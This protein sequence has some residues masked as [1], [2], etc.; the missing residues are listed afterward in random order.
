MV[1]NNIVDVTEETFQRDV[2]DFSHTV[3]VVVDFWADWCQPCKTIG[4]MLEQLAEDYGGAFRLARVNVDQNQ[5]LATA[6]QVQSIPTLLMAFEGA[7]VDRAVGA[8]PKDSLKEWLD[9]GLAQAGVE[10]KTPENAP[11]NPAQARSYWSAKLEQDPEDS[12]AMLGLG[13]I[14]VDLGETEEAKPVLEK[15]DATQ[16][17]YSDAQ[18]VLSLLKLLQQVAEAGGDAA[19]RSALEADPDDPNKR[20]LAA[21][22]RAGRGR[23]VGALEELIGLVAGAQQPVR[24]QAKKAASIVLSA[25]GRGDEKIEHLRR[26]LAGLLY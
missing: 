10:V 9:H 15:I 17:E 23:F 11:E 1:S 20:Y 14:L 26:R 24:D 12:E 3:P 7:V 5:R 21:C 19:V 18:A 13:K 4:P 8:L 16:R 22:A 6:A 2:L 25:A